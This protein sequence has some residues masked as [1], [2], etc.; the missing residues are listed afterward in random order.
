[1]KTSIKLPSTLHPVSFI[2]VDYKLDNNN[3]ILLITVYGFDGNTV[4]ENEI[5]IYKLNK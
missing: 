5:N 3:I 4:Y 2:E 1:M